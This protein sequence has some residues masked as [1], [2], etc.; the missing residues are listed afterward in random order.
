MNDQLI[1][2]LVATACQHPP[3]SRER[4]FLLTKVIRA[5]FPKL[6][7]ENTPY[8]DDALQQTW[9]FFLNNICVSYDPA[10]A[11]VA[12]WLNA[13]LK[14]RLQDMYLDAQ[15]QRRME[16][17]MWQ[18]LDGDVIDVQDLLAAPR[19]SSETVLE[20]VRQWVEN[21]AK[22]E[23]SKIW[24]RSCPQVNCQVLIQRRLSETSWKALSEEFGLS[25]PTLSTFYQRQC[26]P[27]LRKFGKESGYLP[28]T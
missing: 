2:Q 13:Y 25:I 22:E 10:L 16:I 15:N 9:L 19:T 28:E 24:L 11:S 23:L 27:R 21:D 5:I 12:S 7:K 14:R 26:M 20:E 3:G 17:P 1:Q 8:Y 4:Q 18:G 6:W